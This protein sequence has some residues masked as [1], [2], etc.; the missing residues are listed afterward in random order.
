M[1][2]TQ[3]FNNLYISANLILTYTFLGG[4][5]L[6][7]VEVD[8]LRTV[9]VQLQL[10]FMGA[11]LNVFLMIYSYSVGSSSALLDFRLIPILIVYY[12]S[13]I[14]AATIV[15]IITAVFRIYYFG[16]SY[17]SIAGV[18]GLFVILI[19]LM[20]VSIVEHFKELNKYVRWFV[21]LSFC[22]VINVLVYR[23]AL[24]DLIIDSWPVIIQYTLFL[25]LA[26]CLE[27]YLLEYVISSNHQYIMFRL[28]AKVDHLSKLDNVRSFNEKYSEA[29]ADAR[30][31]HSSIS[32]I[33]VDIDFF[34]NVNDTYGH[35][36]GDLVII[37]LAR[38]LKSSFRTED[39]IGRVGGEEFC[40]VI[41]RCS[42]ANA[43]KCAEQFRKRVEKN[44]FV[45]TEE[46]PLSVTVSVGVASYPDSTMAYTKIK[47]LSD[48]ALYAAKR[49]GRNK[50]CSV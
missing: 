22:L 36:T 4:Y 34:K 20:I 42:L 16:L 14:G 10:G 37:E 6:R 3:Y 47:E 29:I 24:Q 50:V 9:K 45:T 38:L 30:E 31:N 39:I 33:M 43:M 26:A 40:I 11:L 28:K 17:S 19:F 27:F 35:E 44:T 8:Q 23:F 21:P 12:L 15:T 1:F 5:L 7:N 41:E 32:C 48:R 2:F 25:T 49:T 18:T 46:V 13:G